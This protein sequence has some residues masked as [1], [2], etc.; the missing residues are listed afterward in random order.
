MSN[1]T[2][3]GDDVVAG[4]A[5]EPAPSEDWP[6]ANPAAAQA[7]GA[8]RVALED[9]AV[10]EALAFEP[11]GE[12]EHLYVH[13]AKRGVTTQAVRQALAAA[14]GVAPLDVSYAGMKDKRALAR[15]WFSIRRPR[16]EA[17]AGDGGWTVLARARHTAKLRRGE[18]A[19]NAFRIRVREV[20]GPVCAN[21][22][23]VAS[24]GVPNY[25]GPQRFGADG[26]NVARAAAWLAAGRPRVGRFAR[27]LHLSCLR[28]FIFNEVLAARVAAG[29]WR[30]PLA[31][32]ATVDGA[33]AGPLWGRGRLLGDGPAR[34]LEAA[35]AARHGV[36]TEAL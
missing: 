28:S 18:L 13:V 31:G 25:F 10:H 27:G 16:R 8:L 26:G 4:P 33:A 5:P 9:F 24:D 22:E 1:A 21:L 15:Q 12:G 23:R 3:W 11:A 29:T 34:E 36:I 2:Q 19:A 6:R 17:F 30:A 20:A 7:H 14:A 32:E 35:V